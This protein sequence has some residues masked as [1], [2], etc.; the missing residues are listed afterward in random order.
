MYKVDPWITYKIEHQFSDPMQCKNTSLI[1][2]FSYDNNR[3]C[4]FSTCY[5]RDVK[6][7]TQI[8]NLTWK[9][10]WIW[11]KVSSFIHN[12]WNGLVATNTLI[13]TV[14]PLFNWISASVHVQQTDG[15]T[16]RMCILSTEPHLGWRLPG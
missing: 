14:L 1:F 10:R 9:S 3:I 2:F 12:F 5:H 16:Q 11:L 13:L 15:R 6:S 7:L 4:G 8:A